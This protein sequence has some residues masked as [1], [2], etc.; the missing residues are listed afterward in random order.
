MDTNNIAIAADDKVGL[1][2]I[3][4]Y[5]FDIIYIDAAQLETASTTTH[6]VYQTYDFTDTCLYKYHGQRVTRIKITDNAVFQELVLGCVRKGN[7]ESFYVHLT[8]TVA[9]V[10]GDNWNNL[11]WDKYNDYLKSC[12]TYIKHQYGIALD[13]RAARLRYMEINRNILL[14]APFEQYDRVIRLLLSLLDKHMKELYTIGRESKGSDTDTG[15]ET[16][17]RGNRQMEYIVYNKTVQMQKKA[18]QGSVPEEYR[19]QDVMRLEIR[20]LTAE[21]IKSALGTNTWAKLDDHAITSFFYAS[22]YQKLCKKLDQWKSGIHKDLVGKLKTLR[23]TRPRDW[24][25][26]IMEDI[27]NTSEKTGVPC[28]LDIEQVIDAFQDLRDPHRNRNRAIRSLL[29]I[30]IKDDVY[31]NRDLEKAEEILSAIGRQSETAM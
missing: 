19:D 24:H 26:L 20:L 12:L 31:R 4:L 23:S 27:R 8:L 10:A 15:T 29:S 1:D 9:N 17:K 7:Y 13:G 30:K 14:S 22:A 6:C 21:K 11:S 16:Y 2:K 25:H 5:N 28:I 18:E 3:Q